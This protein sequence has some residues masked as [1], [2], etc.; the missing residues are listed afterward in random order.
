MLAGLTVK[1]GSAD[2]LT[3]SAAD[4]V[5]A[6]VSAK[7]LASKDITPPYAV[8]VPST[9][10]RGDRWVLYF[11][12]ADD[13][14]KATAVIRILDRAARSRASAFATRPPSSAGSAR[15]HGSSLAR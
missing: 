11:A 8:M 1:A 10:K 14:K 2:D 6:L 5:Q 9:V 12:V 3:A 4:A 7:A 15:P 13:S